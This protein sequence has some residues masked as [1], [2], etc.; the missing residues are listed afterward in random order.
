M[1]AVKKPDKGQHKEEEAESNG[2]TFAINN[3]AL[4][5][6]GSAVERFFWE[7]SPNLTPQFAEGGDVNEQ[8]TSQ[9]NLGLVNIAS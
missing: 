6:A 2:L 8:S 7:G 3:K 4:D 9:T 1:V 5:E